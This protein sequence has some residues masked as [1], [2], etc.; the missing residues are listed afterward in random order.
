MPIPKFIY[1]C[2]VLKLRVPAKTAT[3][4]RP[5]ATLRSFLFFLETKKK[6]MFTKSVHA[7]LCGCYAGATQCAFRGTSS[8]RRDGGGHAAEFSRAEKFSRSG[9]PQVSRRRKRPSKAGRRSET[10]PK[11]ST[12]NRLQGPRFTVPFVARC[13]FTIRHPATT[14][15]LAASRAP[16]FISRYRSTGFRFSRRNGTTQ[17]SKKKKRFF[18]F[19]MMFFMF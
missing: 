1:Y 17:G 18:L 15:P 19:K 9:A 12:R 11:S 2:A 16:D 14:S 13:S 4:I 3:Y 6:K 7:P 5:P 8:K 10:G